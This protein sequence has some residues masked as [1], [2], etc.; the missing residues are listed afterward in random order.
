MR[1]PKITVAYPPQATSNYDVAKGYAYAFKA[2]DYTCDE[3]PYHQTYR[4]WNEYYRFKFLVD[5]NYDATYTQ[6]DVFLSASMEVVNNIMASDP[7]IL[8]IIDGTAIH[9][10]AWE[11]IRKLRSYGMKSVVIGTESPYQDKALGRLIDYNDIVYTNERMVARNLNIPYLPTAY[12]SETHFPMYVPETMRHDVVFVG[13]GF[14]ERVEMLEAVEWGDIDFAMWGH[15]A[16]D[17]DHK[18]AKYYKDTAL[19]NPQA[20]LMYNGAKISLNLNRT[21]IDYD[22]ELRIPEAESASPRVYEVAACGG[23]LIS[24]YRDEIPELFGD[25]VPTFSTPEALSMLLGYWLQPGKDNERREIG[26]A[27]RELAKPHSY[28]ERVKHILRE[29]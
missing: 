23:F 1:K 22:G 12:S 16:I 7:D 6:E 27:L 29:V 10:Q 9:R 24:E 15:Y 20:A 21:S 17:H 18:L 26:E 14:P 28:I 19:A 4:F 5:G 25:L 13:S 3:I 8:I 11:W 2:L